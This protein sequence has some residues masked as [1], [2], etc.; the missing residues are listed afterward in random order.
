M[1]KLKKIKGTRKDVEMCIETTYGGAG[2]IIHFGIAD[3]K[4]KK[5]ADIYIERKKIKSIIS[6]LKKITVKKKSKPRGRKK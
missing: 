5:G 6:H 4:Y 1:P 3:Y 2:L